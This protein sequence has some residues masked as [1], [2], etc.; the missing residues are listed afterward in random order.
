MLNRMVSVV[1]FFCFWN[2]KHYD[3]Q[4]FDVNVVVIVVVVRFGRGNHWYFALWSQK[5]KMKRHEMKLESNTT[6]HIFFSFH[7]KKTTHICLHFKPSFWLFQMLK[8]THKSFFSSFFVF[9]GELCT[10]RCF[11][12]L[13]VT[14][15]YKKNKKRHPVLFIC[16]LSSCFFCSC[17][18]CS[19][20]WSCWF[21]CFSATFKKKSNCF[22]LF[23]WKETNKRTSNSSMILECPF[24]FTM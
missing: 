21:L 2:S 14:W 15:Q 7:P 6:Q 22:V 10:C 12:C 1:L 18:P 23:F 11:P 19:H 13:F 24:R 20:F 3:Q 17:C 5:Y 8:T 4:T 16:L 9:V